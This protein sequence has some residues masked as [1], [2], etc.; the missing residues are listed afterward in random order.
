MS[1]PVHERAAATTAANEAIRRRLADRW[2][3]GYRDAIMSSPGDRRALDQMCAYASGYQAGVSELRSA[4]HKAA[5]Y[6]EG[7]CP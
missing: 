3:K 5:R 1:R 2:I 4:R 7:V 6:A